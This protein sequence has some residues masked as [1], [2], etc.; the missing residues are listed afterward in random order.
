MNHL[1]G[2]RQIADSIVILVAVEVIGITIECFTKTV[3]IIEHR[4]DSIE[5]ESVKVELF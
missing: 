4:S 1:I 2:Q 5:A 3:A